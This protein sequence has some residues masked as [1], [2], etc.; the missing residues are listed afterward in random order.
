MPPFV[1][2]VPRHS[3]RIAAVILSTIAAAPVLAQAAAQWPE[4]PV[5]LVVTVGAG[6]AADTLSRNMS[7]GF[8]Q[9]V[10]GQPLVV[11]NRPGAGGTIAAAARR[12]RE[13]LVYE[14]F[15]LL[16]EL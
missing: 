2:L 14:F 5:R 1:S 10:N 3:L 9:L 16:G 12:R 8:Q 13:A 4:R 7:N 11:E 15:P 6:G